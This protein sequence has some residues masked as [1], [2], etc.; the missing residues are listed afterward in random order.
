MDRQ[1][2]FFGRVFVVSSA[3]S[4]LAVLSAVTPACSEAST[5][6]GGTAED[7]GVRR[8][9]RKPLAIDAE[10]DSDSAEE[11][12]PVATEDPDALLA[13]PIPVLND[14]W[15]AVP[16]TPAWCPSRV[17]LG[18]S[19]AERGLRFS[20]CRGGTPGCSEYVIAGAEQN[21]RRYLWQ[22]DPSEFL[23]H[24]KPHFLLRRFY[25]ARGEALGASAAIDTLASLDGEVAF[26]HAGFKVQQAPGAPDRTCANAFAFDGDRVLGSFL[27]SEEPDGGALSR[28]DVLWSAI[29]AKGSPLSAHEIPFGPFGPSGP[30]TLA[31]SGEVV[32][33]TFRPTD[34]LTSSSVVV[35]KFP[36]WEP[37][38]WPSPPGMRLFKPLPVA[39][40]AIMQGG[41][42]YVADHIY[43]VSD[44]GESRRLWSPGRGRSTGNMVIDRAVGEHVVWVD[45]DRDGMIG[46]N[47]AIWTAPAA[48]NA[49]GFAARCVGKLVDGSASLLV[50]NGGF[51]LVTNEKQR[52][53][54]VRLS[55]G[56]TWQAPR[57]ATFKWLDPLWVDDT[58][59]WLTAAT[60]VTTPNAWWTAN[61][62]VRLERSGFIAGAKLPACG[63][64]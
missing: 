6:S 31:A 27:V 12:A 38:A 1:L 43:F 45:G 22:D 9:P 26:E 61:A 14:E 58:Y 10:A 53:T 24:G 36:S 13:D 35:L 17:R 62:I 64:D 49:E 18:P 28:S 33:S 34:V 59:V 47:W 21:V 44:R 56:A 55:D 42:D 8:R 54:L 63:K 48:P 4:L 16:G 46:T 50:A 32:F 40:G 3:A 29:L 57:I 19:K 39:G 20:P 25:Y 5:E 37:V 52:T 30:T 23:V 2:R 60:N 7:A 11:S 15:V 51:A 41:P